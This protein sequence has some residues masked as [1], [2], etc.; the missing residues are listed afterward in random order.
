MASSKYSSR[1]R[2]RRKRQKSL[3]LISSI[4]AI[5]ALAIIVILAYRAVARSN[6]HTTNDTLTAAGVTIDQLC[7]TVIPEGTP[8]QMLEYK[9]M[10]IS[11]NPEMHIPNYVVWELTRDEAN[12]DMSRSDDFRPDPDVE[13]CAQLSDYR[14]SGYQRGHMMPA[15]DAKFDSDAMSESFLLTNMCPQV[16]ALNHGAWKSLEEKCRNWADIDSAIIIVT[17]PI[18]TDRITDYIGESQVAVPQR[19]FKVVLSPFADPP[20]AIGF[21]M[22]NGK[23]PGGMQAAAVSVDEVEAATGYDFF[24]ALPGDIENEIESQCKFHYWSTLKRE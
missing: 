14:G 4:V 2:K 20:R 6:H 17:G 8:S 22:P 13:G 23:V 19:F 12:G 3:S 21:I 1:S 5:A 9:A 7:E 18:L 11:F 15:A 24:S 10:R 16:G